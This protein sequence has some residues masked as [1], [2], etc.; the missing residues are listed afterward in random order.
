MAD[1]ASKTAQNLRVSVSIDKDVLDRLD[2]Y[3]LQN[4]LASRSQAVNQILA[5]ALG[6]SGAKPLA[7]GTS[8]AVAA[9]HPAAPHS[10]ATHSQ[11]LLERFT[12][13]IRSFAA[14]TTPVP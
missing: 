4:A 5:G 13:L 9:S 2:D 10:P 6:L 7:A 14:D 3:K 1:H 12:A 11:P 8:E